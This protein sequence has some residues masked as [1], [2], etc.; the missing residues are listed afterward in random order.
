MEDDGKFDGDGGEN[1]CSFIASFINQRQS[2]ERLLNWL[3][4]SQTVCTDTNCFDDINGFPGTEHGAGIDSS[5]YG[6]Y[7]QDMDPF[8]LVLCFIFGLLTLYAMNL[9]R[10][11]AV[12]NAVNG[13]K[14]VPP[15]NNNNR[16]DHD[17][18][19]RN[20]REDDDHSRPAI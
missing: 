9:S 19:R 7:S 20:N 6:D 14:G 18:F 8:G 15:N 3:R 5:D 17:G 13:S 4:E 2:V 1:V 10:N 11:R 16:D 12:D